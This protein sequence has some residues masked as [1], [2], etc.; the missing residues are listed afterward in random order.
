MNKIKLTILLILAVNGILVCQ[1]KSSKPSMKIKEI[2]LL[3][4]NLNGTAEFYTN[5]LDLPTAIQPDGTLAIQAGNT[6]LV[7]HPSENTGATYHLA[8]DIPNNKLKEAHQWL[9]KKASIIP[10]SQTSVFADFDAWYAKS[11]YFS[12]FCFDFFVVVI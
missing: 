3:S 5:V 10:V 6:A 11:F 8:F 2:H 1:N 12:H 4:D 7:F 9:K